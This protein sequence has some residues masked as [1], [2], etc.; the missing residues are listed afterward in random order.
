MKRYM[1]MGMMAGVVFLMLPC[2]GA[3]AV[4][5]NGGANH[6]ISLKEDGIVWAWG[7]NL[8]GQLGDG[9]NVS[10]WLPLSMT[11]LTNVVAIS[12]GGSSGFS[13]ALNTNGTVRAW[14]VNANGQ[15]GDGTT[16]TRTSPVPVTGLSNV[17]AVATGANNSLALLADG[18]ARA[19]GQ[20]TL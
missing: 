15:V 4:A 2:R 8:T 5:I 6:T 20:N 17:V 12:T 19:W 7:C 14:G 18:T 16:T 9:T 11:G 10:R 3:E 13:L 1:W